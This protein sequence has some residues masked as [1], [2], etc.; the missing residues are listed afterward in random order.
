MFQDKATGMG[1]LTHKPKFA[2][3]F[4][5]AGTPKLMFKEGIFSEQLLDFVQ[6]SCLSHLN[7]TAE[8]WVHSWLV[9]FKWLQIISA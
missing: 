4:C 9:K 2:M 7:P 8:H 5:W 1:K 3:N 6:F